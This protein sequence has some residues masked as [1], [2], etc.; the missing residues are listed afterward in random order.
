MRPARV[1]NQ[2]KPSK[3]ACSNHPRDPAHRSTIS[4]LHWQLTEAEGFA[5]LLTITTT[6]VPKAAMFMPLHETVDAAGWQV[7]AT[8][9]GPPTRPPRRYLRQRPPLLQ[10]SPEK[11]SLG[12]NVRTFPGL[13]PSDGWP[14]RTKKTS[15]WSTTTVYMRQPSQDW[16]AWLPGQIPGTPGLNA[17]T[18]KT[19]TSSFRLHPWPTN[20]LCPRT[21]HPDL[22]PE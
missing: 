1:Q 12:I 9:V 7:N 2:Y 22:P 8:Y 4:G 19:P 11:C 14:K 6:D 10:T 18:K 21:N 13:L 15:H 3:P 5:Q 17:S 20:L 16:A